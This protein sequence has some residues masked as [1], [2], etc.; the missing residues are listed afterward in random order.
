MKRLGLIL[1]P[2]VVLAAAAGGYFAGQWSS[3]ASAPADAAG[4]SPHD[5]HDH[6]AE[7]EA[8]ELALSDQ[9]RQNLGLKTGAVVLK[10][11]WRTVV[12]PGVVAEKPGQ[13]ERRISTTVNGIVHK[14]FVMPGQT[15]RPGDALLEVHSTGELLANTQASLLKTLQD[16]ELIGQ[17]L[18]R[19]EPLATQG[20]IP[21]ARVLE[22]QYERQRLEAQRLVQTQEL[23][24]RGLAPDQVQRICDSK[25]LLRQF[26]IRAPQEAAGG[27]E[28]LYSVER[29]GV[30]PGKLVQPGDELCDL[31]L[32]TH[33]FLVGLGFQKEAELI[34]RVLE[35]ERSVTAIFDARD[36]DPVVLDGL[37]IQFADNVIDPDT[38]LFH[39]YLPLANEVARDVTGPD[40]V[41]FRSWRFKP[42]QRAQLRLPVEQWRDR[43]VLPTDAVVKEGAE[44]Y[45]FRLNGRRVERVTVGIEY[46]DGLNTVLVDDGSLFAGDTVAFNQAYQ[47][48][49]ALRQQHAAG[50]DP[51]AGHDHAH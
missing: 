47:L 41:M 22:K 21:G 5:D 16:L 34:N 26:T 49:L 23:L 6:G 10:D 33:L 29:I 11:Y 17:E 38:R 3:A 12:M 44:A 48:N 32:H 8:N 36:T 50:G 51:H 7:E 9:A 43:I 1:I 15:V 25:E 27:E 39:F 45:A 40:G 35:A 19:I 24:V 46:E 18:K 20:A 2:I 14:V 31:A 37:K 4:H 30:F 28:R 13:S 42:G